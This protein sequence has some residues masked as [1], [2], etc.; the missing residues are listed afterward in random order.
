MSLIN[1]AL[2]RAKDTQQEAPLPPTPEL[3]FRPVEPARQSARRGPGLLRPGALAVVALVALLFAWQWAQKHDST[4]SIEVNART[5]RIANAIPAPT[6]AA[7]PIPA[8]QPASLPSPATGTSANLAAD[9]T[10]AATE[11]PLADP[12]KSEVTNAAAMTQPTPPKP[13]PLRLQAIVFNPKRPSAMIS[14]KTLFVGD[15]LGALRVVA[16]GR[17]NA[18]LVG[19][20][21]TNVLSLAQ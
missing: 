17:E 11:A 21:Q 5:A 8:A 18:T 6:S 9:T 12:E 1:D 15:K 2:R 10:P 4:G 13:A 14:G 3:P 16:I 7:K 20:G 19:A